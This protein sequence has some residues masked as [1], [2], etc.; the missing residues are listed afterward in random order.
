MVVESV[1]ITQRRII[2]KC[3]E[4]G[5]PVIVATQMLESMIESPAPTRAEVSDVATALF[6]G[7][8]A[9][10]L[11][12]ESAAGKYPVEAVAT[13][14]R[15]ITAVEGDLSYRETVIRR[16]DSMVRTFTTTDAITNAARKVAQQVSARAIVV[17]TK[18][19][20]AALRASRDRPGVPI[21][22]IAAEAHSARFLAL[23]WGVDAVHLDV[24]FASAPFEAL[25]DG[26]VDVAK[27]KGLVKKDTDLLV[28]T[29]GFPWGS[30]LPG[31]VN[32]LR[33]VSGAGTGTWPNELLH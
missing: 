25:L 12:A 33:V 27:A 19:G 2:D 3:H 13:Q 32:D 11:S 8:D 18:S 30:R 22:A 17:F 1:P 5:K 15:I 21:L 14:Q 23:A 26:C 20:N 31:V 28:A 16:L 24:D 29:A 7:A 6:D 10:M 9:V 4:H